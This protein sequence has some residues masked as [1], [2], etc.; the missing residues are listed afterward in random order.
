TLSEQLKSRKELDE[1]GGASY[2]TQLTNF[3]PSSAH[4]EQYAQIVADKAIR[5]RLIQATKDIEDLSADE[6]KGLQELIEE[7][8]M[9]LFAVSEQHVKNDAA[10]LESILGEAFDR[11][12]DLHKNKGRIR[13]VPTGLKD[14]D[15]MLA[16][17]QKSDLIVLAARPSM[18]KTAIMLN[19]ALNIA[20]KADQGAV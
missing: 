20:T 10:S 1:V 15:R 4:L 2:L 3:V 14:L 9:R 16:G 12:D 17:L 18:G 6:S 11:L 19:M 5:R 13:G 8:E 7:A